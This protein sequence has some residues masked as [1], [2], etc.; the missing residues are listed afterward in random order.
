MKDKFE[1]IKRLDRF[2][3]LQKVTLDYGVGHVTVGDWKRQRK[4]IGKWCSARVSND[5]LKDRK[6]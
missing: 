1:A 3:M 6:T 2:E 5:E 4:E